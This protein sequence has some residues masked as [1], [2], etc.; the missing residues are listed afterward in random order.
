MKIYI[1]GTGRLVGKVVGKYIDIESVEGFIDNNRSK[2]EYMGKRVY[3]PEEITEM[4]YDAICVANLFSAEIY[5]QCSK[6]GIDLNRVI[7]LYN[8]CKLEDINKDYD[9][10]EDVLG[11]EY[12]DIVK[13]RYHVIRGVEAYGNLCLS[14]WKYGLGGGI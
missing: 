10:I 9:F 7:F 13:K 6:I 8:N 2:R 14:T 4:K 1:W 12:A 11:Q 5:A 3:A